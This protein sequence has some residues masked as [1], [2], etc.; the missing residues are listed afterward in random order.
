M[1]KLLY[2]TPVVDDALDEDV[3][4]PTENWEDYFEDI[5]DSLDIPLNTGDTL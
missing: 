2:Q 3:F 5:A 4:A 1:P